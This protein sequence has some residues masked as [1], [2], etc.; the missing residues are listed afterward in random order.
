MIKTYWKNFTLRIKNWLKNSHDEAF[1]HYS[2]FLPEKI[3]FFSSFILNQFFSGITTT[4]EQLEGIRNLPK[5]GI[6]VYITKRRSYFEYLFYHTRYREKRL[7]FPSIGFDYKIRI[8]QPLFRLTGMFLSR[9][10]YIVHNK[11]FPDPYHG[12]YYRL[13]MQNG[14]S[15]MISLVGRKNFY[16]RFVRDKTDPIRRLIEIQQSLDK[17]VYLVPQL[18][19]FGTTPLRSIPSIVD[20]LFG[21]EVNPGICRRLFTLFRNPGKVFVEVSKPMDLKSFLERGENRDLGIE[22][23]ALKLRRKLLLQINRHHQSITGPVL[24][25]RE[26][27]KESILTDDRIRGFLEY[28]SKKRNIPIYKARK[29]ADG[30]V[31]EIAA[32]YNAGMIKIMAVV[33]RWIVQTMFEGVSINREVLQKVKRMSQKG[34]LILIPCHKSHIDYLILSYLLYTNNMPCPH[35]AAGKNLS[36]WPLGPIFRSGGAFF[37]RRTFK[38]A[39]LYSKVFSEYIRR[40]LVE[41]FNIEFFIEGGR[42]RT[43][44]MILPKLGL[45]STLLSAYRDGAC[46][47]MIFV[48]IYI[49][50]DRVL[51]ESAYLNE[52]E[53]GRKEPENLVQVIK[54]RRFLKKR[55]GKIY[56]KFNEPISLNGLLS[57][58]DKPMDEM[59]SKEQN[60]ICRNLGH[61]VINAIN[62]VTVVTPHAIVA[63]AILN[64]TKKRF[65]YGD[66]SEQI[67]IYMNYL[68]VQKASFAE[69]LIIDPAGAV[70]RVIETYV[71]RKFIERISLGTKG[72]T[73]EDVF[74]VN[75]NRRPN[76]EYYKNNCVAFFIPA[77]FT[78]LAILERDAFQFTSAELHDSYAFQQEFFKDEFAY[79]VDRTTE[80]FIRKNIK[81]FI[82]DAILMPH[83]TLPDTYNLTSAG[84]R[85]LKLFSFFLKTYF[86]SY[87]IVLN[88]F[89]S[90]DQ[91]SVS[92]KDRLKKIESMGNRMYKKEEIENKE[93]LSKVN[94]KNA[95]KFFTSRGI[96]GKNSMEKIQLYSDALQRYLSL[97]KP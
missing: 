89:R 17:P 88:Y 53:G 87:W 3:G 28:Y 19:F 63:G 79:D 75:E 18:I 64:N 58:M 44:K 77:A 86:E 13:K 29:K 20:I 38:G 39:I 54:A 16:E 55:Y 30:Y 6:V 23:L 95:I 71:Q 84:F 37:I 15:G 9:L 48:P 73:G 72:E 68:S 92:T 94:Y 47:D 66:L 50:Y 70:E 33:V 83:P 32:K 60:V 56:I 81:A 65:S 78:A 49:G 31:D 10:I 14:H 42:S 36:F 51:E 35:I 93:A 2:C 80:Y 76:L 46:E 45:L 21:P 82:D 34:S 85:K 12:G 26:E 67:D 69:T 62:E 11:R 5:D 97:L 40:L 22:N 8:W 59:T 90:A 25:S 4:D 52:L 41:G 43:G 7:P 24:K 27:L 96:T 74:T 61:R 57:Q 91:K 1:D